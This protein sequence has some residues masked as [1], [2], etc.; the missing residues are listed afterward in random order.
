MR[1]K[2]YEKQVNNH[3]EVVDVLDQVKCYAAKMK[4]PGREE[5]NSDKR[6]LG[7]AFIR[8]IWK[9]AV[10]ILMIGI[11]G[12]ILVDHYFL[13]NTNEESFMPGAEN[14]S[15]DFSSLEPIPQEKIDDLVSA[16]RVYKSGEQIIA[17]EST[18]SG[19]LSDIEIIAILY[20]F[21]EGFSVQEA[22][23]K[24]NISPILEEDCLFIYEYYQQSF[25]RD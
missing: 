9:Y 6:L 8:P 22:V 24:N 4:Y 13:P 25:L 11:T 14:N 23:K 19:A 12:Y 2:D 3:I 5:K 1:L 15:N 20:S 10:L 7:P 21:M 17:G 18:P 16:Y